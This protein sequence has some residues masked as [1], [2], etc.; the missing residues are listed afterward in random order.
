MSSDL[1]TNAMFYELQNIPFIYFLLKKHNVNYSLKDFLIDD[2]YEHNMSLKGNNQA[3]IFL[4]WYSLLSGL[5]LYLGYYNLY[6]NFMTNNIYLLKENLQDISSIKSVYYGLIL[7]FLSGSIKVALVPFHIWLSKVHVEASTIGSVLLA[8]IALKSGYY[9][10]ILFSK[11][12]N[13]LQ[14]NSNETG[15][16]R[17]VATIAYFFFILCYL[18]G[19]I[20]ISISLFFQVDSKRWIA[21]YSIAHMQNYYYFMIA[22]NDRVLELSI[23]YGMLAHSFISAGLFFIVGYIVDNTNNRNIIEV[24]SYLSTTTKTLFT[25]F[26]ISNAA[27]P[28]LGLFVTEILNATFLINKYCWLTIIFIILSSSCL[29]SGLWIINKMTAYLGS[30]GE[31]NESTIKDSVLV[32]ILIPLLLLSFAFG[33]QVI[34]PISFLNFAQL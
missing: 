13:L 27:F 2:K 31:F 18:L 33:F 34:F 9:I 17:E 3:I 30:S 8:G 32:V 15:S 24:N 19:S 21:L 14:G 20:V 1:V 11:S 7:I 16:L 25:L 4:L 5:F 22:S 12:L 23:Y 26:I 29:V 10:H 28:F 6:S